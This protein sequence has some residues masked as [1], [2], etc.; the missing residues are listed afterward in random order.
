MSYLGGLFLASQ[1]DPDAFDHLQNF[2]RDYPQHPS[3]IAARLALSEIHL[4]QAPARPQAAREV[5]E[6]LQTQP[7]TLPQSERLDYTAIWVELIDNNDSEL[8]KLAEAFVADWPNSTYLPEVAM[9]LGMRHLRDKNLAAAR[10]MFDFVVTRFPRS[11]H[12][13]TARFFATKSG[14]ADE[15]TLTEWRKIVDSE[16]PFADQARHELSLLLLSMDR[17][18]EARQEMET[19]LEILPDDSEHYYAVLA[20]FGFSYYLEALNGDHDENA[21]E[22]AASIF[23]RLSNLPNL[24]EAWRYNAAVRRAKCLEALG[25]PNVALEIYRSMITEENGGDIL[26]REVSLRE[27]EWIFRAGFSAIEILKQN[28]DWAGAIKMAD[29]LSLK[30]G[31][32]AIEA[33]NLAEQLRLKHWVWD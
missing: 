25:R 6:E 3:N 30:E 31:P 11:P 5:F 2:I 29:T 33:G 32:R 22:E 15:N 26:S 12:A 18:D 24:P 14:P 4:N 17:Y 28:E 16:G 27:S 13:E 23:A 8:I 10:E 21:L 19:L 7:L 1:G 20:D 9:L